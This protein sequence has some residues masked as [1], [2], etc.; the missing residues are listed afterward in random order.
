MSTFFSLY[1]F[2]LYFS[3]LFNAGKATEAS[4][5]VSDG[6]NKEP[7]SNVYVYTL[8]GEEETLS[9]EKGSFRLL[10]WQAL[11]VTIVFEKNGYKPKRVSLKA[12][13]KNI[14]VMLEPN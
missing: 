7:L 12:D 6:K 2:V 1:K 3:V 4:G 13:Q 5:V 14:L 9:S 10:S 8:K 11:P